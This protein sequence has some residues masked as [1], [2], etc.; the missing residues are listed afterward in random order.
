MK[1]KRD[2]SLTVQG[3]E[4]GAETNKENY[5]KE[6]D[7]PLGRYPMAVLLDVFSKV[8]KS[9]KTLLLENEEPWF[10]IE[11]SGMESASDND[12]LDVISHIEEFDNEVQHFCEANHHHGKQDIMYYVVGLQWIKIELNEITLGY[13]G[14]C[15]NIELRAKFA[16]IDSEWKST[17]IYY[18]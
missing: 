7:F 1:I 11:I 8:N 16:K 3:N 14:E 10:E 18:Q 13:W 15:C 9:E 2:K 5:L 12:V 4:T 17:D 6:P